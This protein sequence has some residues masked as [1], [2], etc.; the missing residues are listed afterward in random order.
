MTPLELLR[1]T[2]GWGLQPVT[3]GD[4]LRQA[5]SQGLLLVI[6]L[7]TMAFIAFIRFMKD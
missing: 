2:T 3:L 5:E 7:G 1:E 4:V 6:I